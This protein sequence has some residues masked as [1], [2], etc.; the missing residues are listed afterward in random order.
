MYLPA[1]ISQSRQY[2]TVKHADLQTG[3]RTLE[4]TLQP[5]TQHNM[6]MCAVPYRAAL[7][8]QPQCKLSAVLYN[9]YLKM[10]QT[11]FTLV[12]STRAKLFILHSFG[13][14]N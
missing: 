4:L 10:I 5:L 9:I 8:C 14:P 13:E 11:W 3:D 1:S 6:V 12:I 7:E 2:T